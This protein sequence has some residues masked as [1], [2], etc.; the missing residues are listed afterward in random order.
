MSTFIA[1]DSSCRVAALFFVAHLVV[2]HIIA[3]STTPRTRVVH[4]SG[5]VDSFPIGL[6]VLRT[7]LPDGTS[8]TLLVFVLVGARVAVDALGPLALHKE[9]VLSMRNN[10]VGILLSSN[11]SLVAGPWLQLPCNRS[12]Q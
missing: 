5:V 12:V 1:Y 4:S 11:A 9:D 3:D 8:F 7:K 10:I 6:F 2:C